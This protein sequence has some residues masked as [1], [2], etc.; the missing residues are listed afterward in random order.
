MCGFTGIISKKEYNDDSIRSMLE[1]IRH[2]GPDN[3]SF[4]ENENLH[5]GFARLQ[6]IDL[7]PRSN[8]PMIDEE[9]GAVIV[10][11]GEVY[12][13]KE[14]R[15]DLQGNGVKFKTTSDTEVILKGYLK[16]GKSILSKL[17][18]M[19]AF[20]IFHKNKV[21]MARDHFGI[22]P[23]YYGF[24]DK[25]EFIFGSELKALISNKFFSP[26]LNNNSLFSYLEL[27]HVCGEDTM[28]EGIKRLKN[29]HYLE[30]SNIEDS[31]YPITGEY[32][33]FQMSNDKITDLDDAV[34]MIRKAVHNSVE[35]HKNADVKVGTFLSGGIDSSY[36]TALTKPEMSFSVGFSE[37]E[38][39]FDESG[40]AKK[41]CEILG[42]K[43][44][45]L[46]IDKNEVLENLDD[47]I[48]H[49]DEPQA[50]LSS[51][52]LYFLSK[53]ARENATVVLS[54]EGADEF[55]GGYD[56][57]R[58]DS[59][60][61]KYLKLPKNLRR[62]L[63]GASKI[64]PDSSLK[65]R[66]EKGALEPKDL[67]V[68]EANISSPSEVRDILSNRYKDGMEARQ[69]T[70][71]FFKNVDELSGKQ[72]VDLNSFM[73]YDILLKG[74]RMS[75]AHSL[76]L[77]V[78]FLDLEVWSVARRLSSDLKVRGNVT[79]FAL[80][81]AAKEVLPE[82]WYTRPKKGFPVPFR[83]FL[84][85]DNFY[86]KFY[87]VL[88]SE[89]CDDFFDRSTVLD[90]LKEHKDGVKRNHRRLYSYYVFLVWYDLYI[91]RRGIC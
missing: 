89:L 75:M 48:Y 80:R 62:G 52:P 41:L 33:Q 4:Y 84:K 63:K 22:K 43:L 37:E 83:D 59:A 73:Q 13:Y 67:F 24:N 11:N 10:F 60:I 77:R 14:L 58:E 8:Q 65:R 38:G 18:G 20:A 42:I 74:D 56:L 36:I 78:P 66:M 21:F 64:L 32:F 51:I 34:Y 53:L 81:E 35:L 50:N 19:F 86:N 71:K 87:E 16:Y 46:I 88:S 5:L 39:K 30:I 69:F 6:I 25:G 82:E 57:Y 28:I 45:R 26:R 12:N 68:G 79:K 90:M 91:N 47:I 72:L 76:E 7:D 1:S 29:G 27:Q 23:L 3:L 70:S 9:T 40:L 85:E 54:G 55:F 61:E 2:R 31:L 15:Q 49:L 17:R 44:N